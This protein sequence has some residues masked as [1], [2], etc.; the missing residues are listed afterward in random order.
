MDEF[1]AMQN[2]MKG[3]GFSGWWHH[4]LPSLD[5]ERRESLMAAAVDPTISHRAIVQ[6]MA[7]WGFELTTAQV[8]HWRRT[9]VR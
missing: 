1:R 6:V 7:K 3:P 8:G 2:A 5:D 4:V 9:H